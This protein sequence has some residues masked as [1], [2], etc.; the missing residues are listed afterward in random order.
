VRIVARG[1]EL[2]VEDAGPGI[3]PEQQE[4]VFARFSR[5]E[6]SRASGTGLGLAIAR[7]LAERMGGGVEL[8]SRPGRT[9]FTLRLAAFS[10]ENEPLATVR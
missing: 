6:G 8:E 5:L 7:E 2:S 9:V 4:R 1:A 10:R 3:P